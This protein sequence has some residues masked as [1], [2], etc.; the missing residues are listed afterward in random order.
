MAGF[1]SPRWGLASCWAALYPP[2]QLRNQ[3]KLP[4]T[5][6][7]EPGGGCDSS[8]AQFVPGRNSTSTAS[9][10]PRRWDACLASACVTA[11][12]MAAS[13]GEPICPLLPWT[14]ISCWLLLASTAAA[15]QGEIPTVVEGGVLANDDA[16]HSD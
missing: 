16:A 2:P 10:I 1:R 15:D 13:R 7:A 8:L 9:R 12:K 5:G 4:V 14:I 6:P 3:R 11:S